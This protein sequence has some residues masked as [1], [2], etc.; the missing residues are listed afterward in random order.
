V[1]KLHHEDAYMGILNVTD[2]TTVTDAIAPEAT[3]WANE[4]L[5]SRAWVLKPGNAF[6]HEVE[7]ASGSLFIE[8]A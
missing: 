3:Q 5:A 7:D 1:A 8:L 4:C 6:I 2:D